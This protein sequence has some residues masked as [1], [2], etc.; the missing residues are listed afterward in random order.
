TRRVRSDPT[1]QNWDGR[2]LLNEY[3]K[4]VYDVCSLSYRRN[5]IFRQD[6]VTVHPPKIIKVVLRQFRFVL[7]KGTMS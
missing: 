7:M 2:V 3:L 6:V 5:P 1:K 4:P